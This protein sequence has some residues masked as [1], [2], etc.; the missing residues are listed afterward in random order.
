MACDKQQTSSII[1]VVD[2]GNTHTVLGIFRDEK[3]VHHWRLTTRKET[4]SDEVINRISGLLRFSEIPAKDITHVG[5]S[6]VVPALE[7][8]WVKALQTLLH[9]NVLVVNAKNCNGLPIAYQNPAAAGS[10]RLCNVIALRTRGIDN[11]IVV[12]MGTAT[13]FDVLKDGAFVGGCIIPGINAALDALTEKAARLLPV[14]I[15]WPSKVIADNTDDAL[16]AG[17]LFGFMAELEVLIAKFKSEL[18]KENVPV[19]ATGG[20]GK[21]IAKRT[22][23]ID[24]YDPFLTLH[25]VREVALYGVSC[26]AEEDSDLEE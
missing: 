8:P 10:D 7:R 5:L 22:S 24:K 14:T 4:T 18:G 20:W 6:T 13:T 3:L 16:R 1:F 17:L 26:V 12:D 23:L 19:F 9:R 21:M 2:V 11:A 15:E 25:G